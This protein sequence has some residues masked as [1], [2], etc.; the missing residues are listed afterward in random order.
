MTTYTPITRE[1]PISEHPKFHTPRPEWGVIDAHWSRTYDDYGEESGVEWIPENR[2]GHRPELDGMSMADMWDFERG[3][4][5][6]D[7]P[8]FS[9]ITSFLVSGIEAS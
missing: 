5:R 1:A 2:A 8:G 9:G 3:E 6:I 4:W 7:P